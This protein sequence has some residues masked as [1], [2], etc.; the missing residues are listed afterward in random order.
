MSEGSENVGDRRPY[1]EKHVLLTRAQAA[2]LDALVNQLAL[3]TGHRITQ[4][5][6]VR[7]L[8]LVAHRNQGAIVARARV[9]LTSLKRHPAT[10]DHQGQAQLEAL[11]ATLI[12]EALGARTA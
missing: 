8:L 11:M 7:A 9:K 3:E 4:T 1:R 5:D 6:V 2:R 10:R 12:Q